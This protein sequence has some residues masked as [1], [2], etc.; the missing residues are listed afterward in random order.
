MD[1]LPAIED[2]AAAFPLD[3]VVCMVSRSWQYDGSGLTRFPLRAGF[4]FEKGIGKYSRKNFVLNTE[5]EKIVKTSAEKIAFIQ[6]WLFFGVLTD[7]FVTLGISFNISDFVSQRND[8]KVLSLRPLER[9]V[10]T[11]E[12]L[13]QDSDSATRD[14]RQASLDELLELADILA[15]EN[16]RRHNRYEA[17]WSL[18]SQC[19]LSI[20]LLHEAL[21]HAWGVIYMSTEKLVTTSGA[22]LLSDLPESRMRAAGWCPSEIAM[23]QNRFSVTGRYFASRLRRRGRAM[24][25]VSCSDVICNASQIDDSTYVTQHTGIGCQCAHFEVDPQE[26]G[27]I[28]KQGKVPRFLIKPSRQ[29]RDHL[30][31]QLVDGGPYVA[32]SHVWAHGLGNAQ[33]NS[34]PLCQLQRLQGYVENLIKITEK[35]HGHSTP[36]HNTMAIWIDTLGVPLVQ[37]TRKLALKLL[38]RTYAESN[39]CLVI[40]EELRQLSNKSTLEEFCLRFVFSTWARRLWTFQEGIVTWNKLYLQLKEGPSSFET[41]LGRNGNPLCPSLR[42]ESVEEAKNTLPRVEDVRAAEGDLINRLAEAC[43]YRTTSRLSDQTFCLASIA[44]FDVQGIVEASTHEEKMKIFLLQIRDLPN[45]IIFFKGPKMSL[46]NFSWAPSSFLHPER[47]QSFFGLDEDHTSSA[48]CTPHGLQGR[49]PGF[50]LK[51]PATA[52]PHID[53]YYF[54]YGESWMI[55]SSIDAMQRKLHGSTPCAEDTSVWQQLHALPQAG[56]IVHSLD[57]LQKMG[58]I[59]S[60]ISTDL[61]ALTARSVLTVSAMLV[62]IAEV[63]IFDPT[64]L[65]SNRAIKIEGKPIAEDMVFNLT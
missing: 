32:I 61:K 51:F 28:L 27:S 31:L 62:P 30:D 39:Y 4:F 12:A 21:R 6:S 38:P 58:L 11:W 47:T 56:L 46:D 2:A 59:F 65:D 63:D 1:H 54:V 41:S 24:N 64:E 7:V 37:E 8:C 20:Q 16:L 49:W 18:S 25:H 15:T 55:I 33:S 57:T 26:V 9:Y 19:A 29:R 22:G 10:S 48:L 5:K 60:T 17:I 44:G 35:L 53:L 14:Q 52:G 43:K 13:E 36:E 50:L 42:L 3:E 23:L 45:R 40:D 34:L